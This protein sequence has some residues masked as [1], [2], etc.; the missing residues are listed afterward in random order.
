M[1]IRLTDTGVNEVVRGT[2]DLASLLEEGD[3][4]LWSEVGRIGLRT[5]YEA[6][7]AQGFPEPWEDLAPVTL[8]RRRR[9]GLTGDLILIATGET[10]DAFSPEGNEY[11]I[12]IVEPHSVEFGMSREDFPFHDEGS[13]NE[14]QRQVLVYQDQ[15]IDEFA[16]TYLDFMLSVLEE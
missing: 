5:A 2:E 12:L 1:T 16:D 6:F 13:D 8:D 14:P 4:E 10:Q 3:E 9:R 7:N 15:T 11:T